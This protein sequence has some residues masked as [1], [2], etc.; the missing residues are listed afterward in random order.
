MLKSLSVRVV[1]ALALGIGLGAWARTLGDA[2]VVP[3]VEA[4]EAFGGLWLNALRM[5]VVPL[6]F[7]LV[8]GGIASA[9]NAVATGRLAA[10]AMAVF[11]VLIVFAA[12]YTT[13][14][15]QAL[16][17]LFPVDRVAA[18]AFIAGAGGEQA[19][20]A[21]GLD[22]TAWLQALA[23]ANA[24]R[25]AA[26]EAM[27]GLVVFA[28][29]FG[30]AATQI[31]ARARD[32]LVGL[33]RAVADTMV[34]IVRWVLIVAPLG[35]FALSLGVGLRA[36]LGAASV[37]AHYVLIVSGVTALS[38]LI[39]Y[40]IA[41]LF[42]RVPLARFAPA[43]APVIAV[44]FSTQSSLASLPAMLESARTLG[45]SMRVRELVLP[46]AVAVFRFTSPIANLAVAYFILHL[47][48]IEPPWPVMAGA[49]VVAIAISIG[50]VGLPGQVSFFSSMAPIC[51]SLGAPTG[52]L[53]I[54]HAV[55]VIPDIFRTIGNVLGHMAATLIARRGEAGEDAVEVLAGSEERAG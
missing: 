50:T 37:L 40:A 44:A 48:G 13:V 21:S 52:L 31:E 38:C 28:M 1:I 26:E 6:V 30:F 32:A 54:L 33:L 25:A 5:T 15:T 20:G 47:Y 42:G 27:L 23:P 10:R 4:I 3:V 14:A 19:A 7:A 35:V 53:G 2:R 9:A 49:M 51:L 43:S 16:L 12:L 34:V 11:G 55:E 24:V 18:A 41:L 29:F 36:G 46:L 39:A 22:F 8:V 17:S 45:V